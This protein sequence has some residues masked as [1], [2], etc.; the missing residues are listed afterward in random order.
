[1]AGKTSELPHE[2]VESLKIDLFDDEVYVFTPKGDLKKLSEVSS[3]L[4]LLINTHE[5]G[6]NCIAGV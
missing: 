3:L 5:V 4:I 2:F 6:N 1:M